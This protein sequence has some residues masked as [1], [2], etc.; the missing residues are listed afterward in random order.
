[1]NHQQLR[2]INPWVSCSQIHIMVV[3]M[4]IMVPLQ[5]TFLKW[6]STSRVYM[7]LWCFL[8]FYPYHVGPAAFLPRK[9]R[10]QL[11]PFWPGPLPG[12]GCNPGALADVTHG[13]HILIICI[14][15]T[16]F[17][18]GQLRYDAICIYIY[19]WVNMYSDLTPLPHWNHGECIGLNIPN[20]VLFQVRDVKSA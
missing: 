8:M 19:I 9:L 3:N 12:H 5:S 18:Y 15:C 7:Y 20:I 14:T 4:E 17:T 10:Q 11:I 1:M 16:T 6:S 2:S 13:I